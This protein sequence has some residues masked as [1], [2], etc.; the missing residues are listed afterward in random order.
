MRKAA[1]T[2]L[3]LFSAAW[4]VLACLILFSVG[5]WVADPQFYKGIVGDQRIYEAMGDGLYR[6]MAESMNRGQGNPLAG[7]LNETALASALKAGLPPATLAGS[8]SLMVDA[9][10]GMQRNAQG[11]W[12]MDFK[13]VKDSLFGTRLDALV[14]DYVRALPEG[15]ALKG[16]SEASVSFQE[17]PSNVTPEQLERLL[18]RQLSGA[19]AAMPDT[20]TT[21]P[22][23]EMARSAWASQG[24]PALVGWLRTSALIGLVVSLGFVFALSLLASPSWPGRAAWSGAV[25]LLPAILVLLVGAAGWAISGAA[26]MGDMGGWMANGIRLED[27]AA[28]SP[29][30]AGLITE[31]LR[32]TLRTVTQGFLWTGLVSIGVCVALISF[33]RLKRSSGEDLG[34]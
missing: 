12:V 10:F 7:Q 13:P 27:G 6:A 19:L 24:L 8:A 11:G 9:V 25:L 23:A 32:G 2:L 14:A 31:L 34:D 15:P 28:V 22:D 17:R 29:L 33:R 26:L 20:V 4:M 30:V 21:A 1:A 18:G 3:Y 5:G 16:G